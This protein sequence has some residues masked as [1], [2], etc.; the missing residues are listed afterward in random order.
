M[1]M[2]ACILIGPYPKDAFAFAFTFSLLLSPPF[3][4]QKIRPK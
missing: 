2:V 1:H 3:S 4:K